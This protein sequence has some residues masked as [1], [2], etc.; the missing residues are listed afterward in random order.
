MFKFLAVSLGLFAFSCGTTPPLVGHQRVPV[1]AT[2]VTFVSA[3]TQF[4]NVAQTDLCA[5]RVRPVN[6]V[7]S[8]FVLG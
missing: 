1:A 2:A 8:A 3:E 7:D 5:I 4:L 6:R